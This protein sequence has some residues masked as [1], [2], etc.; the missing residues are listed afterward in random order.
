MGTAVQELALANGFSPR[1]A[2]EQGAL[3]A[4]E[5]QA[6][7]GTLAERQAALKRT[8][9]IREEL[10]SKTREMQRECEEEKKRKDQMILERIDLELEMETETK[11]WERSQRSVD[12]T[13]VVTQLRGAHVSSVDLV[14]LRSELTVQ[15]ELTEHEVAQSFLTTWCWEI[16]WSQTEKDS[17][18]T[19]T[20]IVA[21]SSSYTLQ[22]NMCIHGMCL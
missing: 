22:T 15:K 17:K 5:V 3:A 14:C 16:V 1:R 7:T 10:I 13:E 18:R 6:Q 20:A 8:I 4:A 9:A 19:Q 21:A 12:R 11:I 2:K